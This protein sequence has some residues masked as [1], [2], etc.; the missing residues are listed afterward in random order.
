[1]NYRWTISSTSKKIFIYFV[2][3]VFS[4]ALVGESTVLAFSRNYNPDAPHLTPFYD[5]GADICEPS[6][7]LNL[8]GSNNQEI[9]FN[10]F[11][12]Q[13]NDP[14]MAAGIVGNLM[15]ESTPD[16]NPEAVY[17]TVGSDRTNRDCGGLVYFGIAQW[18]DNTPNPDWARWPGLVAWAEASGKD[19][20]MLE[21]QLEY[22][23]VEWT[24]MYSTPELPWN[25]RDFEEFIRNDVRN[26]GIPEDEVI[27]LAAWHFGR[28][29]ERAVI[30]GDS[31]TDEN[32]NV[33]HLSDRQQ[34]ARETYQL[35]AGSAPVGSTSP[36]TDGNIN[37]AGTVTIALDPG[38]GGSLDEYTD[39]VTGL[40]DRETP[41]Q[42]EG[43]D[44]LDVANRVRTILEQSGDYNVV[45]LRTGNE[46]RVPSKRERVDL[47]EASNAAMAISIHTADEPVNEVWPQRVG[48]F[49]ENTDGTSGR[50]EFT[51]AEVAE[52]SERYATIMAEERE[53]TEGH[54][55]T[56]DPDQSR[57]A[58]S[59]GRSGLLAKGNT[60]LL[61]LWS[62]NVPFVYNE[63]QRDGGG[64]ALTEQRK[65]AYAEGIA[66]GVIRAAPTAR[67]STGN[68]IA[69]DG[70]LNTFQEKVLAYAWPRP[71]RRGQTP[72]EGLRAMG[73]STI[74]TPTEQYAQAV[75]EARADGRYIGGSNGIDCGA[76]VTLLLT[77]SGF[78]PEYN[79]SGRGGATG[80]QRRWLEA[81]WTNLGRISESNPQLSSTSDLRPGDVA[82]RVGH[83]FVFVGE[84]DGFAEKHASA[85]LGRRAPMAGTETL[86]N[87][88]LTWYRKP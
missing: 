32:T 19:P 18:N 7:S 6:G 40:W 67:T 25:Y 52:L 84:I 36:S 8:S 59:L 65:Q 88:A 77:N 16:I 46:N 55:V 62:T 21:T 71:T 74:T 61:L 37:S 73:Q 22:I 45:M 2:I 68:C 87:P 75:S 82:M 5:P 26:R 56:T 57:Q 70:S 35:Y 44:V 80:D 58:A 14:A 20:W 39:P 51:N 43:D 23:W 66:N 38:H 11:L 69:N 54:R 34:Y 60:P 30:D 12:G 41:N 47:A 27:D 4:W 86:A 81:N 24:E 49:R 48:T 78:E 53:I 1:M 72:D 33:Q 50:V 76:F 85:S 83:T 31:S 28:F 9:A 13:T 10:Y 29:Y 42:P 17:C 64:G 15:Q 79:S 3:A 63:I